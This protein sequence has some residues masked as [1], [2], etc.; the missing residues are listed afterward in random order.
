M[1][2]FKYEDARFDDPAGWVRFDQ[3]PRMVQR[4]IPHRKLIYCETILATRGS[5]EDAVRLL[6]GAWEWWHHGR[7]ADFHLNPDGSTSQMLSP[8]WWNFTRVG[9]QVFS[10]RD[11]PG[12][13]GIR[14]PLLMSRHFR[15][16]ASID[17]YPNPA[18]DSTGGGLVIRGRYHGV[19]DHV[20]LIPPGMST[21]IHLRAEA[22]TLS[23][24]FP[25]GTGYCGLLELL[26][27]NSPKQ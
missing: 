4:Y 27:A 3:N 18:P 11:L 17:V 8:V 12:T 13:G 22:G 25:K 21:R 23:F 7:S 24:P 15:G 10:R 2:Q 1:T 20:P 26:E 5:M 14:L 6:R 19:E 9:V 16:V